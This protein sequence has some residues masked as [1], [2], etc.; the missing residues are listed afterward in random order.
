[1]KYVKMLVAIVLLGSLTV[2]ADP[3]K[4]WNWTPPTNYEN[5][6]IIPTTDGLSYT[7]YCNDVSGDIGPPYE[8][9]IPLDDPGAPPSYEDMGLVVAGQAGTYYCVATATSSNG[10][11][12]GYSNETNFTVTVA[13]LGFVPRPPTNLT[14]Q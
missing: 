5:G 13:D 4:T 10:S 8:V 11:E 7:L 3:F 6:Q 1:M 2:Q 9:L 12:S 14:F